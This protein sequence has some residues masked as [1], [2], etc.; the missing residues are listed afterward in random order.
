M[1]EGELINKRSYDLSTLS[2][3]PIINDYEDTIKKLKSNQRV[4]YNYSIE[5]IICF[6]D[7][8]STKWLSDNDFLKKYSQLGISFLLNFL[9]RNSLESLLDMALRGNRRYSDG[10]IEIS[11]YGKKLMAQPR[12]VITHWL[13]GNVPILGMISLIQGIL[14][15]N[16][17][18]VK[19]PKSNGNILPLF[20]HELKRHGV[21][22]NNGRVMDGREILDT[23][24]L[25]YC[26][27]GDK[28]SQKLLS[29]NSDVRVAWGGKEAV[30]SIM[31]LRR[32][33]GTEDVIFG[34]KYSFAVIGKNSIDQEN[35][36]DLAYQLAL[37]ASVFDQYGCNS[38]HTVFVEKGGV[39]TPEKFASHLASAMDKVLKRIPKGGTTADEAFTI[40][41]IRS[42][43][44]F[45]GKVYQSDGTEWTV[46]YSEEE[47][48][49]NA[50]FSRILFVRPINNIFDIIPF[51]DKQKQ[52]LGVAIDNNRLTDFAKQVTFSGIERITELGRMS[53]FDY[54]WDGMFPMDRFVRWV[55]IYDKDKDIK[56]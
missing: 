9:R 22:L 7:S 46:I 55:S 32:R 51:I 36:D 30:E 4:I 29:L 42:E 43:Y 52:T 6:F 56:T 35:V 16:I 39:I 19:L 44:E 5:D 10:F 14:T 34:P 2:D 41:N 48:L 38:P 31:S 54:P 40:V 1:P 47:G 12:G 49:A 18:V 11:D 27:S 21:D 17:N 24:L 3:Y 26:E 53:S 25:V 50:Y 28:D 8:L 23:L 37:D 45:F 13:A 20:L 33:Y 15:K